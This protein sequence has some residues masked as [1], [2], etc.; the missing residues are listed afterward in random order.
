MTGREIQRLITE[1][2]TARG[3]IVIRHNSGYVRKNVK[4]APPGTPDLQAVLP[5][6]RV[7][8]IEVK[9]DGD[10]LRDSQKK[11]H[12]RLR[13]MGHTVIVAHSV[14]DVADYLSSI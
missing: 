6:G 5:G 12:S 11:M 4:L 2:L 9:G 14:D 1:Y 3:A 8:W 7:L 13:E 10:T